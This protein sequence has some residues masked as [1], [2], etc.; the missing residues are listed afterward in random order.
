MRYA[1]LSE[2]DLL[3]AERHA[4]RG[5]RTLLRA[6]WLAVCLWCI[7]L[8]G[9]LLWGWPVHPLLLGALSLA[10]L[11]GG[12]LLAWR[13]RLTRLAAARRLDRRF[14]LEEQLATAVEVSLA[15]PAS[16]GLSAQLVEQ[17]ATTAVRVRG[18]LRKRGRPPWSDMLALCSMAL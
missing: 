12:A 8:G 18:Y 14:R 2:L 5:L 11:A 9:N 3:I 15:N 17:A 4:R 6:A 7:S 16:D 10:L 1:L 13:G